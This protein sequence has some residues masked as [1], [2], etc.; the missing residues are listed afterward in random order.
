MEAL[1]DARTVSCRPATCNRPLRKTPPI[2]I[3]R[4]LSGIETLA[5]GLAQARWA[6]RSALDVEATSASSNTSPGELAATRGHAVHNF[7]VYIL[8]GL[9]ESRERAL[10]RRP[11]TRA[12]CKSRFW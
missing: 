5:I 6:A 12:V 4:Y 7:G 8:D 9:S 10:W 3:D 11:S 2:E 1:Q